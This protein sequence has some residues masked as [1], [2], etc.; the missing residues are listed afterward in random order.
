MKK[1]TLLLGCVW[2]LF[3]ASTAHAQNSSECGFELDSGRVI[4]GFGS[5]SGV[6]LMDPVVLD[7]DGDGIEDIVLAAPAFTPNGMSKAG[8]LYVLSG[9]REMTFEALRDMTFWSQ[10]DYRFD[11][12]T[13]GGQ[14]G[15]TL[16]TGD[17]NGDGKR[18][19]AVAEP[20]QMGAVYIFYGGKKR[21][22]GVFDVLDEKNG[23]DLVFRGDEIGSNL[24]ISGCIG[25][26]NHD[27][28]DDLVLASISKKNAYGNQ[29]SLMTIV[30][31]RSHWEK[32]SYSL[33]G[34][35]NGKIVF[36]RPVANDIRVVHSCAAGD[37][38]DDGLTDIALGM[39]LD[40]YQKQKAAGSV[41]IIY[42]PYKFN[43]TTID[44]GTLDPKYGLRI[45]GNQTNAQFGYALA[46]G[47]ISG[48]GRVDLI[49][50]A[51]NRLVKGPKAEGAV[52]V[53]EAQNLPKREVSAGRTT[54]TAAA[55][56]SAIEQPEDLLALIGNGGSFGSKLL[57]A[58]V[59]GDN[60]QDLVVLAPTAGNLSAGEVSIWLGGPHFVESIQQTHRP[61][62]RILGG[63]FMGFGTGAA[64]GDFNGDGKKDGIFRLTADPY[65][66]AATGA[67]AV[68][69]DIASLSQTT[70]LADN[71]MTIAAPT[72]GGE[73]SKTMQRVDIA[74]S[75]YDVW[76]SPKGGNGRSILCLTKDGRA[77]NET[78]A[79]ADE[80]ACDYRIIGPEN[81]PIADF[82]FTPTPTLKPQITISVPDMPVKKSIGFV[83]A[84]PLPDEMPKNLVLNLNEK[85]LQSDAQTFL[86]NDEKASGLGTK[87]E[88]RD[89]DNDGFPDLIIGAPNRM[90]DADNTGTVFIVKGSASPKKGFVD[91]KSK[92]ILAYDGFLNERIGSAWQ[93]LDFNADNIPDLVLATSNAT[94][95]NGQAFATAYV[96]YNPG[97]RTPKT[98]S[99][100]APEIASLQI[101]ASQT[102]T[103]FKFIPQDVDL[104]GDGISDLLLISPNH[105]VGVQKQ[106]VVYG[107]YA[108]VSRTGGTLDL[109]NAAPDFSL[110]AGRNERL[111]D[112]RFVKKDGKIELI[113]AAS[114]FNAGVSTTIHALAV[115]D[116]QNFAGDFSVPELT[117]T[118]CDARLPKR[119]ELV[120]P[121]NDDSAAL[122]LLFPD[123]GTVMTRQGVIQKVR[124]WTAPLINRK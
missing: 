103:E 101:Q 14:L 61:D 93:I 91:L 104:N 50:S 63:D 102:K 75:S 71:F 96:L 32:K 92:N 25:D 85:T 68:M 88:W 54:A 7:F 114:D 40:S 86:L 80:N 116:A 26:F 20:G 124:N 123:D 81:Y 64:F 35:L 69:G 94:H 76:F 66:R 62:F 5:D 118:A 98:Y 108:N 77:A 8:S 47:D 57:L 58:D 70:M 87:I 83:A 121:K 59:N 119:A 12:H 10:F 65:Q 52:Y 9:R 27:G 44:L 56:V 15:M 55:P 109:Q 42:Q 3:A 38:N 112:V 22:R 72:N 1:K 113:V 110:S 74:G 115:P 33:A 19:L 30:P 117:K 6:R 89:L 60:R 100:R 16:Y 31:M 82:D 2:V 36:S 4:G 18:D 107:F 51:P 37:F 29:A 111:D 24:G 23:A 45:N 43:G 48:D 41:T 78:I 122:W 21:D 120:M 17:F 67:Y 90:I 97:T 106:G 11:G 39:P 49:V 28:I 53:I 34:K 99:I 46:A 84:I 13:P 73:L 79:L 105:R 95:V